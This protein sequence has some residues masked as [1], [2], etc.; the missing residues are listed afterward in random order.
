MIKTKIIEEAENLF[1]KNS[2]R[3]EVIEFI[4]QSG[5]LGEEA[6]LIASNAYESVNGK[7][8]EA[9]KIEE[10]K[11]N[12]GPYGQIGLGI[13]AIGVTIFGIIEFDR[14]F[15]VA[16]IIGLIFLGKGIWLLI[17]KSVN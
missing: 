8:E 3:K 5:I 15:Y 4:E 7:I 2:G 9:R 14:I 13:L 1:L 6:E 10:Q 12:G 11:L 17:N 16:G